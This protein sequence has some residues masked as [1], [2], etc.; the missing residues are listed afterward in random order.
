MIRVDA[1]TAAAGGRTLVGGVTFALPAGQV[2]ALV[3][4]SGSGKTTIGRALLREHAPGV[5]LSGTVEVTGRVGYLPQHPA[6]VLNPVRRVGGVLREIARQAARTTSAAGAAGTSGAGRRETPGRPV[7]HR[8]WLR[9]AGARRTREIAESLVVTA[10]GQAALPGPAELARRFPH[11]LSGGQQQRLVL[12]QAL[13][14]SP[15]V[16]VADEPTTGQDPVTKHQITRLLRLLANQGMAVV[17]LTHDFD[18]VEEI[19]DRIMVLGDGRVAEHGPAGEVLARPRHPHTRRLLAARPPARPDTGDVRTRPATAR[20]WSAPAPDG[21]DRLAVAGLT[22]RHRSAPVISDVSLRLPAGHCLAVLGRSGDGKTTL[23][24]C[25]AG[26]HRP[27]AGTVLLDGRPLAP[28]LVRRSRAELARVQYVFQDAHASFDPHRP[29]AAQVSRTAVRLRGLGAGEAGR[30]ALALLD[31]LGL[32]AATT[33][34]RPG[35]LSGGEL[36]RAALAR[37]LLAA[38]DVLICDEITAGLDTV[39]Q[40]SVLDL[41]DELR[42]DGLAL[43]LISHDMGVAT[44]LADRVGVL[45]GGRLEPLD[46]STDVTPRHP[47]SGGPAARRLRTSGSDAHAPGT[48]HKEDTS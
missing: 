28:A 3:G 13:L 11:Q 27:A 34:R 36:R 26:L 4:P 10:L 14:R 9:S 30:E 19:A 15:S 48:H 8:P 42:R 38:P 1:L 23:A 2:L 25:I 20:S 5:V 32:P 40:A 12:A 16:I 39:T 37:A 45:S 33:A 47:P 43:L 44:R 46:P 24:R 6:S 22:A 29:V 18:V 41:L 35:A 17:L 21:P 7:A 31:R